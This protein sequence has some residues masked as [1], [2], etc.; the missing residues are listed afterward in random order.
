[1]PWLAAAL[2]CAMLAACGGDGGIGSSS[3]APSAETP[4]GQPDAPNP[5]PAQA[6]QKRCA[7]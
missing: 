1:M 3:G 7:P 4:A 6:P 5:P 2:L